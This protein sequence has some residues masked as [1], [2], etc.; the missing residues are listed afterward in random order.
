M[1]NLIKRR[2]RLRRLIVALAAIGC[3]S[4]TLSGT[5]TA[6]SPNMPTPV[7]AVPARIG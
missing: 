1:S 6:M 2:L 5:L 7:P 3:S 4:A